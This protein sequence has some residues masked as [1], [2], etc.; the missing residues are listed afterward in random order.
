MHSRRLAAAA[1]VA[2]FGGAFGVT[3]SGARQQQQWSPPPRPADWVDV[4]RPNLVVVGIGHSGTRGVKNLLGDLGMAFCSDTYTDT[5][6]NNP[7]M[8]ADNYILQLL[9]SSKGKFDIDSFKK[10]K[11]SFNT[12]VNAL[13]K[14]I[15][16]TRACAAA[17]NRGRG[18]VGMGPGSVVNPKTGTKVMISGLVNRSDLNGQVGKVVGLIKE[19]GRWQLKLSSGDYINAKPKNIE[20]VQD[21]IWGW[22]DPR[23][24][25]LLPVIDS[26]LT[27]DEAQQLVPV[28]REVPVLAVARDPR[29]LCQ[30]SNNGQFVRFN[31]AFNED[32]NDCYLFWAK[33]W[34]NLLESEVGP[35]R[36]KIVRIEDLSM[37]APSPDGSS[38]QILA[39]IL[40]HAYM[41]SPPD[42]GVAQLSMMHA[43]AGSYMGNK[44]PE[45][46]GSLE[47]RL[48]ERTDEPLIHATMR[49]LGYDPIRYGLL[50]PESD[51]VL[52]AT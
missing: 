14:G 2:G 43:Y 18:P 1:V 39:E 13:R 6:D 8:T 17:N 3:L 10:D 11:A 35:H 25:Y 30:G 45:L 34:H 28:I 27:P 40:S 41:P 9:K 51:M 38:T 24:L 37:P 4:P 26:A 36:T 47:A 16:A 32:N 42:G 29:D 46:K 48:A 15:P 52:R 12:A 20:A 7:T 23:H 21:M 44:K 22:K 49:Q 50:T 5:G 31:T 19:T 33:V